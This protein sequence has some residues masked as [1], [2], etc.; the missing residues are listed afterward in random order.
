M[1]LFTFP[2][3]ESSVWPQIWDSLFTKKCFK[4]LFSNFFSQESC[5]IIFTEALR[6]IGIFWIKFMPHENKLHWSVGNIS[7]VG[8]LGNGPL[9]K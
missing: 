7:G 3:R 6:I 4:N 8:N 5:L 1:I 2:T 9:G